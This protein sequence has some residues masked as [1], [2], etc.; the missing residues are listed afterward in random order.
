MV[1]SPTDRSWMLGAVLPVPQIFVVST[2]TPTQT[3]ATGPNP[4]P[5]P[6]PSPFVTIQPSTS[7]SPAS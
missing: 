3:T 1:F 6:P 4:S 5:P 7:A 2:V